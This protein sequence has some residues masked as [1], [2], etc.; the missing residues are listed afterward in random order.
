VKKKVGA[1]ASDERAIGDVAASPA[2]HHTSF[3]LSSYIE[4]ITIITGKTTIM[5]IQKQ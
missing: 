4:K 5:K 3:V 2:A 1:E